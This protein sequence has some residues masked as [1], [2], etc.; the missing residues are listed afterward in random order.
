MRGSRRSLA[1]V[2][3]SGVAA[4]LLA[5]CGRESPALVAQNIPPDTALELVADACD[6]TSLTVHL[7]WSGSDVDGEVAHYWTRWDS[8]EWVKVAATEGVYVLSRADTSGQELGAGRHT[9]AVKAVDDRGAED[10]E[11]AAVSFTAR[12]MLPETEIVSGPSGIVCPTVRFEWR[13]WDYDG[14]IVGYGYRLLE[15]LDTGGWIEVAGEDSVAADVVTAE[16]GPLVGEHRFEVWSIDNEG[17]TDPSPAS[18]DFT[19]SPGPWEPWLTLRTN[20]FGTIQYR[21]PQWSEVY[22]VPIPILEREHLVFDWHA[23][24]SGCGEPLGYSF[25]YDDTATWGDDFSFDDTHF[26]VTPTIGG[27][28]FYVSAAEDNGAVSRGKIAFEV[29]GAG[30]DEYVLIVD[31]YN[32]R[33][34]YP[35]WGTDADR[36]ALYDALTADCVRPRL[37]W[38]TEE[39]S[40]IH[41]L[42][43]PDVMTLGGA[44]TVIWYYDHDQTALRRAFDEGERYRPLAGY[45]RVGGNIILCGHDGLRHILAEIYPME[46][47]PADSTE[48]EVFVREVLGIANAENTGSSAN[49]STPWRY[50]YC[51]YGAIPNPVAAGI[52]LDAMYID[53]LGTWS[54]VY[55]HPNPNYSHGGLPNA[56]ILEARGGCHAIEAQVIDAYLNYTVEGRPCTVLTLTGEERGKACY[57]GF[58]IYYLQADQARRT[59]G[60]VL[61][62][63][64]E[65]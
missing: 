15:W 19:C 52:Q 37:S 9:F 20:V 5:G 64:G 32:W 3:S 6:T 24:W 26:E 17:D 39:H 18:R 38:D 36:D 1:V 14:V 16:F 12:N 8:L 35:L 51:L 46:L 53:S 31:D 54:P 33:E 60:T 28:A 29:I 45:A 23:T 47:T 34:D 22:D 4:A 44:S 2:V 27:H 13:G 57:F 62:R 25:A 50:G 10:P 41:G 63:F 30:L 21:G 48:A 42:A 40:D 59:F 55:G 61:E 7:R 43:P 65:R 56:E 11:P 49:K 58:P